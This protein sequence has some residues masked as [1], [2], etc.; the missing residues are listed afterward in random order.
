MLNTALT[1][2]VGDTSVSYSHS[3]YWA[4]FVQE[5]INYIHKKYPSIEWL[6]WGIPARNFGISI[7]KNKKFESEHPQLNNTK[8][9][10]FYYENHFSKIK[11]II[12]HGTKAK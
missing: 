7:S 8:E 9:G 1:C 5:L 2:G 4:C 12:W 6:L 3:N 11:K 10:S